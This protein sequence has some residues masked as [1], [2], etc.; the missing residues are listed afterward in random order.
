M[1]K[2]QCCSKTIAT[3][4]RNSSKFKVQSSMLQQNNRY[5]DLADDA[6]ERG[7]FFA[8]VVTIQSYFFTYFVLGAGVRRAW[9]LQDRSN[10]K[11]SVPTAI[12]PSPPGRT[13]IQLYIQIHSR[14]FYGNLLRRKIHFERSRTTNGNP[15]TGM[16]YSGFKLIIF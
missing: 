2:V 15:L 1:F 13:I 14:H 4:M 9:L 8:L 7:L 16:P 10:L 6:D 5:A 12:I 11:V 3:Q